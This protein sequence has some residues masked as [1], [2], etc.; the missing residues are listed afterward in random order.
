MRN[1]SSS[2]I[3]NTKGLARWI[4]VAGLV[5]TVV[6]VVFAIFAPWVAPVRLQPDPDATG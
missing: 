1:A 5:I 2:T 6:F 4:F 3:W